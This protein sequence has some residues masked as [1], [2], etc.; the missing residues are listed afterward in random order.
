VTV[1]G[2]EVVSGPLVD[3][4]SAASSQTLPEEPAMLRHA[5]GPKGTIARCVAAVLVVRRNSGELGL[6]AALSLLTL[7]LRD[8]TRDD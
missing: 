1:V 8:S 6:L 7:A 2:G 3:T 5:F 4:D